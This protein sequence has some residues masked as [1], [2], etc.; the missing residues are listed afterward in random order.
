MK[1]GFKGSVLI[2]VICTGLFC[3]PVARAAHATNF[4]DTLHSEI[5][6]RLANLDTNATASERRAL[7]SARAK[8]ERSTKTF[9]ADLS[10]LAAAARV[11]EAQANGAALDA[12]GNDALVAYSAEAGAQLDLAEL[13][14]GTNTIS[15]MLSNQLAQARLTLVN[16]NANTNGVAARARAL[17]KA[18]NKSRMPVA[19]IL[20]K[21]PTVPFE[22]PTDFGIGKNIALTETAAIPQ[23]QTKFFF[24][25][26]D[27]GMGQPFRHYTSDNPEELGTWTYER[28]TPKTAVIHADLN[29]VGPDCGTPAGRATPHNIA[30]TFTSPTA[31]TFSGTNCRG[32]SITGAFSID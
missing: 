10:A 17:A 15:K 22:A 31:G 2:T 26:S 3:T 19:K 16:A 30:L 1:R 6:N 18:F 21:F 13:H 8:L 14:V 29:F 11:W 25:V 9:S 12:L 7:S 20:K 27:N 23:D 28:L 32:E 5:T 24:H 4:L